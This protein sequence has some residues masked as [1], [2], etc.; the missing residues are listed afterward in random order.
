MNG[1]RLGFSVRRV[2][3]ADDYVIE[4]DVPDDLHDEARELRLLLDETVEEL[5]KQRNAKDVL[6]DEL[7]KTRAQLDAARNHIRNREIADAVAGLGLPDL[8]RP[9]PW[10]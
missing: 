8:T 10:E 7:K 3:V 5:R 9:R 4:L 6:F 1:K 2:E